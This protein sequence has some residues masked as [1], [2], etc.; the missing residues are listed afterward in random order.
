MTRCSP[1]YDYV[2]DTALDQATS[3]HPRVLDYGCG[4]GRTVGL[5]RERGMD[6]WGTDT[7]S[8]YYESWG[9]RIEET[10]RPRVKKISDDIID[11]PDKYFDVVIS[12]QVF[13][14]VENVPVALAEISR[15]LKPGG[16]FLALFPTK[17]VWF[18]GHVGLYFPHWLKSVPVLQWQYM[19]M[20]RLMG[21]G[22][23]KGKLGAREWASSSQK[24]LNTACVYHSWK[25]VGRWWQQ[26]FGERPQSLE[27]NYMFYRISKHPR[28][29]KMDG[30]VRTGAFPALLKLICLIRA[31]RVFI[32]RRPVI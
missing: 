24:T 20:M 19:Y 29:K 12:N 25:D 26:A 14:H 5:G 8:N 6:I 22:Y 15:V 18:E 4:R 9:D 30:V 13:E 17:G 28:L 3:A 32:V 16:V 27:S 1:N 7:F 11:F 10:I 23:Y 31:G 21:L 2:L